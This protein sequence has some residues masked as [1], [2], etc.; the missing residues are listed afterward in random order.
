MS[1]YLQESTELM[2]NTKHKLV[3]GLWVLVIV[4]NHVNVLSKNPK[5]I[6][7]DRQAWKVKVV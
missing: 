7:L 2:P 6:Q 1:G 5:A 3:L 4:Q